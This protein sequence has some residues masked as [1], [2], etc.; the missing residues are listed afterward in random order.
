MDVKRP[1]DSLPITL[2]KSL[3]LQSFKLDRMAI[4]SKME[5]FYNKV[6]SLE[7]DLED[8]ADNADKLTSL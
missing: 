7:L 2:I 5:V 3:D 4:S 8:D 1:M 6:S